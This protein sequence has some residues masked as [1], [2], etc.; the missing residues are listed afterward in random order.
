MQPDLSSVSPG[1]QVQQRC[2]EQSTGFQGG[3]G[4]NTK[5]LVSVF[6]VSI[7]TVC[8]LIYCSKQFKSH[9]KLIPHFDVLAAWLLLRLIRRTYTLLLYKNW[10][11]VFSTVLACKCKAASLPYTSG[12]AC[13]DTESA[14]VFRA[15]RCCLHTP[16]MMRK[17]NNTLNAPYFVITSTDP[18]NKKYAL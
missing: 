8:H 12:L 4:F 3:L 16:G 5:L 10:R 1:M 7:R 17:K 9:D 2:S 15:L 18:S 13:G 14:C 11:I 6:S